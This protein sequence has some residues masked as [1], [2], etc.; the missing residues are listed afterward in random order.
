MSTQVILLERVEKLGNMG[1][2][3]SVKPGYARNYLLPQKKALRASKDNV[4]YFEAQ[5]KHLQ[6]E[7]D[8]QKKEAEKR[9]KKLAGTKVAL[10]RQASESGQLY[11]SVASRDIAAALTEATGESIDRSMVKLNQ[12]YKLIGLFPIDVTLHPEVTAEITINIARSPEEAEIQ[13]K[14][15]K[16]LVAEGH[17][18]E[19]SED[20]RAAAADEVLEDA[21][22]E[23]ALEAE[24]ER[25]AEA[26]EK[27]AEDA[28][29]AEERATKKAEKDAAKAAA[30][31]AEEAAAEAESGEDT[32]A[33]E[34]SEA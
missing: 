3:V 7:S 33:E 34:E 17:G 32:P 8:K 12:N 27:A 20:E 26:E 23:G 30:A 1:D 14:T 31:E 13:A 5:K 18:D 15:G 9:A 4:A 29:K 11:G 10:I 28:A 2:V 19:P 16:A 24:K 22:E 25:Q 21:L 6:A